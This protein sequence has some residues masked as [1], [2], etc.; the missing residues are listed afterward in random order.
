MRKITQIM[1]V[2][3]GL[4]FMSA[5]Q[6]AAQFVP[7]NEVRQVYYPDD[8]ANPIITVHEY[9]SLDT[10]E[11]MATLPI[12]ANGALFELWVDSEGEPMKLVDSKLV[13][14]DTPKA[15][16]TVDV[17]DPW[18]SQ[19]TDTVNGKP[20]VRQAYRTRVDKDYSVTVAANLLTDPAYPQSLR[21]VMVSHSG[22]KA[23]PP[24]NYY[25][26]A[27]NAQPLPGSTVEVLANAQTTT[28]VGP[29]LE[30]LD[31]DHPVIVGEEYVEVASFA[32]P[33]VPS[34]MVNRALIKI[35][36]I[37]TGKFTQLSDAGDPEPFAP[38]QS[39]ND[40][41]RPIFVHF[42]DVYP[43]ASCYVQI[44]K[45][46]PESGHVGTP[47][48]ITKLDTAFDVNGVA[49]IADEPQNTSPGGRRLKNDLLNAY[50]SRWGSGDY[51]LEI[52]IKNLPFNPSV[53]PVGQ[54]ITFT[55]N[56][57]VSVRGQ[58]GTSSK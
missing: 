44:Y 19:T 33:T 12:G 34:W 9:T 21:E 37:T 52:V 15:T 28:V 22:S 42:N 56:H 29:K 4:V 3:I 48:E 41:V 14:T 54:P 17:Q 51:T 43:G 57:G 36:P 50:F 40:Q 38:G 16:L 27:A 6:I 11:Q 20:V 23:D 1:A 30:P 7:Q 53:E 46:T 24:E 25:T 49:V 32:D 58:I 26:D 31:S 35:W 2:G 55:V 18:R 13:H 10:G 45:G 39:F 8:P 5:M 47:I